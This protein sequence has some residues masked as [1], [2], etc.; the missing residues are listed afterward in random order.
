MAGMFLYGGPE[1]PL[2]E[3]VKVKTYCFADPTESSR[4][5]VESDRKR[6]CIAVNKAKWGWGSKECLDISQGDVQV[7]VCQAVFQSCFGLVFSHPP[8]LP[9]GMIMYIP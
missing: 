4:H 9:F 3:A 8:F 5:N 2:Q 6:E 7:V 1:K